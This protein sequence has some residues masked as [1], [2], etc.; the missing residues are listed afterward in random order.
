MTVHHRTNG[1]HPAQLGILMDRTRWFH[2][3]LIG[4]QEMARDRDYLRSRLQLQNRLFHGQGV[5]C[6]LEVGPH[7][8][9]EC[10]DSWVVVGPGIAIDCVG[11]E[12]IMCEPVRFR[13][14]EQEPCAPAP[15]TPP[16]TPPPA[17]TD[18]CDEGEEQPPETPAPT[19]PRTRKYVLCLEYCEQE[20]E[21]VPAL[22]AGGA[23]D[24][25]HREANRISERA[26][27]ALHDPCDLAEGC[28]PR[29]GAGGC[30]GCGADDDPLGCCEPNCRCG[31]CVPLALLTVSPG[32]PVAIR[33]AGRPTAGARGTALTRIVDISWPHGGEVTLDDLVAN[34]YRL[35]V[36]FD[37]ELAT[38]EA[39][40]GW[41]VNDHTFVVQYVETQEALEFVEPACTPEA[42]K[43]T[44]SFKFDDD[45]FR[46][47]RR[48]RMAGSVVYVTLRCDF[49]LDCNGRA[50]DGNHLG[51]VRPTGDG[52]P[53]GTFESWFRIVQ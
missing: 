34:D 14:V 27:L 53:G 4:P 36:T 1:G 45:Y 24:G 50:V 17:T 19:D 20:V 31:E 32:E 2:G 30:T 6:G 26:V 23:C 39:G 21:L 8:R 52:V 9:P 35:D 48:A 43:C 22:V 46:Q 5:V 38:P 44:A 12:L 40:E 42:S 47:R 15:A 11:R 16:P 37:R 49:I 41:G 28:W 25:R 18:P 7:P 10:A 51:G 29:P 13:V 3:Q 33:M